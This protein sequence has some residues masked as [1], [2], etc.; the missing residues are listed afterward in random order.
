M[1]SIPEGVPDPL[2][3][4][5]IDRAERHN[6]A[7]PPGVP[8]WGVYEHLAVPGRSGPAQRVRAQLDALEG[9]GSV[10]R[11]RRH[12]VPTWALTSTGR[13]RLTRARRAGKVPELPESPQ[14]RKWREARALAE[15]ELDRFLAGVRDA[16]VDAARLLDADPAA[17]SDAWLELGERLADGCKRVGQATYCLRE[18]A[19]PDDARPDIDAGSGGPDEGLD[20][21]E[22]TLR[23]R[24]IGRRNV[25]LWPGAG[26]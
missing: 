26:R 18:W 19:E 20:D 11:S 13:R 10:E 7:E 1:S 23:R 24:R 5:A 14:H 21:A 16:L 17:G 4:A 3:L 2:V 12:G 8:V 15:R 9:A 22:R 6:P 25:Q